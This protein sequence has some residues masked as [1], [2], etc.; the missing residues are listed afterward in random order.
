MV[1]FLDQ[2]QFYGFNPQSGSY[3]E[4]CPFSTNLSVSTLAL[5]CCVSHMLQIYTDIPISIQTC[6]YHME[7]YCTVILLNQPRFLV[8][9][10]SAAWKIDRIPQKWFMKEFSCQNTS[11]KYVNRLVKHCS[12]EIQLQYFVCFAN[13]IVYWWPVALKTGLAKNSLEF[14]V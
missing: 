10:D 1:H 13:V 2:P 12:C 7:T 4:D 14:M 3:F 8:L 9:S 5:F 11:H 6:V